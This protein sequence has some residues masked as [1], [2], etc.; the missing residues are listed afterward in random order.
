MTIK[1][2][3]LKSFF[4]KQKL[5]KFDSLMDIYK[6]NEGKDNENVN[7]KSNE[8]V[9][10][11]SNEIVNKKSNEIVNKKSNEIVNNNSNKNVNEKSNE[12]VNKKSN[13]NVN[14]KSNEI[15]NKKS[16]EIVNNNSNEIVNNNLFGIQKQIFELLIQSSNGAKQ[17]P[18]INIK[19]VSQ[20][21]GRNYNV[22][23]VSFQRLID[24]EILKK[25]KSKRGSH[26]YTVFSINE[27]L[28]V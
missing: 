28:L 8:I 14:E 1:D 17:T 6:Q 5:G 10:K 18:P 3:K 25:V 27:V 22:V 4:A 19:K 2:N 9:N 23:R 16:N 13:K 24:K 12:I 15:V 7:K 21:M 20:L 11:K 26:G